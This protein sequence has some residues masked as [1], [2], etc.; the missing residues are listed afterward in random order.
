MTTMDSLTNGKLRPVVGVSIVYPFYKRG[1]SVTEKALT[2]KSV[3]QAVR[4][5]SAE[6]LDWLLTERPELKGERDFHGN[7]L[8]LIAAKYNLIQ[9]ARV[10]ISHDVNLNEKN[11]NDGISP[12]HEAS[13]YNSVDVGHLLIESGCDV[14]IRDNQEK[15]PLHHA[16]RRGRV[17]M[18]ELLLNAGNSYI[19]ATDEDKL[20]SLHESILQKHEDTATLLIKN[21]ADVMKTEI[22]GTTPYMFASA[23]ELIDVMNMIWKTVYLQYG[24]PRSLVMVNQKDMWGNTALHMAVDNQCLKSLQEIIMH[25][26]EL[27]TPNE[28]GHTPLH[29]AAICVDLEITE[30]LLCNGATV[31]TRDKDSFTPLQRACLYNRH[32]VICAIMK[33]GGDLNKKTKEMM[34]PLILACWKGHLETVEFLLTNGAQIAAVD[35]LMKNALHWTVQNGH[36]QVLL[37]L[38]KKCDSVILETLDFAEQT[39]TH[40]AAKLGNIAILQALIQHGCKLDIRD[41]DGRTPIHIAAEHDNEAAVEVLYHSSNSELNDGDSDGQTPLSLAVR[42]G[43]Y[44]TVKLLLSLGADITHRD[45]NL[46]TALTVAA[47]EGHVMIIKIL[48]VHYADINATDKNK[49]TPLHYASSKGHV[50]CVQFLL[51]RKADAIARNSRGQSPLDLAI[52]NRHSDVAVT[53]MQ[54][55]GW[56]E[57]IGSRD[58]N[59]KNPVDSMIRKCPE[60]FLLV[61]KNS[62]QTQG[63]IPDSVD[64]TQKFDFRFIDPGPEDLMSRNRRYFAYETMVK[65]NREELL[66]HPLVQQCLLLKW[67]TFGRPVYYMDVILF[68]LY[69]GIINI[70]GIFMPKIST[71]LLDSVRRCP[72]TLNSTML[73]NQTVV[74]DYVQNGQISNIKI[75]S[76]DFT[77]LITSLF[78]VVVLFY[79][80]ELISLY[81]KRW[82]YF[83]FPFNYVALVMLVGTSLALNPFNYIP[84]EHQWRAAWIATLSAWI[85]LISILRGLDVVG[86][87]FV[88][89]EQVFIS[90]F[91]ISL[92]LVV[93]VIA[94]SQAFYITMS[95]T[96]G[97]QPGEFFPLTVL[98]MTIGEINFID[99]F[100]SG[101]NAAFYYD[102][103]ILFFLF[104]LIMPISLMNLLIGVA[105]GDTE[106]VKKKAYMTRLSIQIDFLSNTETTFPRSLQKRFYKRSHTVMPNKN[107]HSKFNR[108]C[109]YL[110]GER[111]K[112]QAFISK[113]RPDYVTENV[114]KLQ[115][116]IRRTKT[117]LAQATSLQK[118]SLELLKQMCEQLHV[119]YTLDNVSLAESHRTEIHSR[120]E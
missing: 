86:I 42:E 97:F 63:N 64:F 56:T 55:K 66:T 119:R 19:N 53:F 14:M 16:A 23:V 61:M 74:D 5:G 101:S 104:A 120:I 118:Q 90:L 72:I 52:K 75:E 39:I 112:N 117:Q 38:L 36:L 70:Y 22:N 89:L 81:A 57:I 111:P 3:W 115:E 37:Y 18:V 77:V 116:E 88:M 10:L 91:K 107:M 29:R 15:T 73:Q 50:D 7:T 59:G 95:Q 4:D 43:Q 96:A 11:R 92:V 79:I 24:G 20:T 82:R 94:F 54:S 83:L 21:G 40:Y 25:G 41:M 32:E 48:L 67:K 35:N 71:N 34:T 80:R 31:D 87:Y 33:K 26:G 114:K 12:L 78:V 65:Y 9:S 17:Q 85:C 93:F 49:N 99:N 109:K 30:I 113:E 44:N 60:A 100:M 2:D 102:N 108:F 28:S 62:M 1:E 27:D 76:T 47:K 110:F 98:S 84:C 103:L 45:E 106:A 6:E 58:A 105:V 13:K 69:L 8:L 68:V 51:D 46:C